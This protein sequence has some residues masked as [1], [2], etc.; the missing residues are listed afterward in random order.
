VLQAK[1]GITSL[2]SVRFHNEESLHTGADWET[3][4]V[5]E[6]MPAK[7]SLDLEY[8]RRPSLRRDFKIITQTLYAIPQ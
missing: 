5:E 3:R 2:A 8:V 1:P 6:I 7:L 4:Y